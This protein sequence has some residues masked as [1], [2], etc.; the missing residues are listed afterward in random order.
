MTRPL[1]PHR[2]TSGYPLEYRKFT[3][4]MFDVFA[5]LSAFVLVASV[6]IGLLAPVVVFFLFIAA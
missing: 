6:A 5:V 2:I 3:Q 4:A 1:P